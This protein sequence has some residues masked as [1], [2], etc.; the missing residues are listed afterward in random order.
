MA[1]H[2]VSAILSGILI[3]I[4]LLALTP[5]VQLFDFSQSI[6]TVIKILGALSA[7]IAV[8]FAFCPE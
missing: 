5:F 7:F 2:P 3:K 4:P 8:I 6:G 1:M